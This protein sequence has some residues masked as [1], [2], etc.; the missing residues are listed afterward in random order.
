MLTLHLSLT[1]KLLLKLNV[2]RKPEAQNMILN[3]LLEKSQQAQIIIQKQ[4][5]LCLKIFLKG[6]FYI[7]LVLFQ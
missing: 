3:I 7:S 4:S 5:I 6:I 2:M 1:H